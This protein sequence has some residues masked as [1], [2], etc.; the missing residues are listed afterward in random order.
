MGKGGGGS[1]PSP[2]PQIGRAAMLQAQTGQEMADFA[3]KV[4]GES[5][6]RQKVTDALGNEVTQQ[7][8][9]TMRQQ[10]GWASEDR[11]RYTGVFQPMQDQYIKEAKEWDSPERQA[12]L[13]A[14]A[15]GDVMSGASMAK[16]MN[17]RGMAAMGVNPASGRFQGVDRAAD[18]TTGLAAAGAE[19]NARSAV[20]SQGLALRESAINLGNGLPASAS[21]S[22]SMGVG[23][24]SAALGTNLAANGQASGNAGI[25]MQGLGGQMQGYAGQASTLTGLH[26]A[27]VNAWS[28]GQQAGSAKAAGIG[29]AVGG[30]ASIA[31]MM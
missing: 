6:E 25:M 18:V 23:A 24:G 29:Q 4:Y 3:K 26:N 17:Q 14:E 31:V 16:D 13:A 28:A 7:Q 11:K 2:D 12:A 5:E 1:A 21:S 15:R 30:I 8:L 22:A 9:D 19:N 10:A 20:R 27:N